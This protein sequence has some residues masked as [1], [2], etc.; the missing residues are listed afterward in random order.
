MLIL[1]LLLQTC[2]V[3]KCNPKSRTTG[4][5]TSKIISLIAKLVSFNFKY[6]LQENYV[7]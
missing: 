7:A 2:F 6:Y 4:N 5:I 1:L 3:F